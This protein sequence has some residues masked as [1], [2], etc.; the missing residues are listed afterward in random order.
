MSVTAA[1]GF[2]ASGVHAGIRREPAR[3]RA[4][5]LAAPCRGRCPLDREP[6]AGGAGARLAS[7]T[8]RRPSRRRSSSTPA[9]PTPPRAAGGGRRRGDG[10][11]GRAR[12]RSRVREQVLVLSTG[13][14]GV[15]LPMDALLPGVR[16]AAAALAPDG[17]DAAAEAILTTDSGPKTAVAADGRV[18][19]RRDGE[20]R[21]DDPPGAGD[22]ARRRHDRLPARAGASRTRSSAR[23]STRRFNRISVDGECSTNDAVVLLA[24]GASDVASR[25]AASDEA[26]ARALEDVCASLA[27]QIVEDGEGATVLLEVHV[28]QCF[29]G[30]GSGRDRETDRHL[31]ARQDGRVRPRPE[32]GSRAHGRR[33]GA[34]STAASPGSSRTASAS[35]STRRASSRPARRR[36]AVPSLAGPVCRIEVNVGLGDGSATTSPPTSATTTCASTRSTRREPGRA[37]ARRSRRGPGGGRGAFPPCGRS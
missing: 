32:L 31:A 25:D 34:A 18:H 12:A 20:G 36:A 13:V 1:R 17:G 6:R 22:D 28:T 29:L 16:A 21:R 5:A 9:W 27:R 24:N 7:A 33:L 19:R 2:V 3:S 11:R 26:F 8:L 23:P 10:G 30:G 37:Q 15:P 4:R 35:P 14:I